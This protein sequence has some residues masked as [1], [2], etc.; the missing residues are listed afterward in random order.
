MIPFFKIYIP[1]DATGAVISA[2][3]DSEK[4]TD[5]AGSVRAFDFSHITKEDSFSI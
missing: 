1:Y 4:V 3:E 2:F 5:P